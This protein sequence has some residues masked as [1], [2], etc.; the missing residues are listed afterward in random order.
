MNENETIALAA[1]ETAA[2][3]TEANAVRDALA[4][5]P[6]TT[7]DQI[8]VASGILVE[9]KGKSKQLEERLEEITKPLNAALRSV[10]DLFRPAIQAYAEAEGVLK[11]KIG[12]AHLAIERANREAMLAAQAQMAAGNVL[13][14]AQAATSMVERP[15]AEG[16]RTQEVWTFR[17]VNALL[18]PR[19][20]LVVDEKKVRAHV[21]QHG[22]ATNIP[23]IVVEK[24]VRIIAARGRA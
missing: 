8:E 2:Q 22:E 23:G 10:R 1:R 18:V 19:E 20:F 15:A 9:I 21:A 17:V 16:V 12:D 14:A 6:V 24:D 4:D 5:F 3:T 13:A 7:K 11:R